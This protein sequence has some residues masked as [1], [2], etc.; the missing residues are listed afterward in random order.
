MSVWKKNNK[1]HEHPY[2]AP[3][4]VSHLCLQ[5]YRNSSCLCCRGSWDRAQQTIMHHSVFQAIHIDG[6]WSEEII[7]VETFAQSYKS[8]CRVAGM[9]LSLE[10]RTKSI[11]VSHTEENTE[12]AEITG[13][14]ITVRYPSPL[15][16]WR[17]T[18]L[19]FNSSSGFLKHSGSRSGLSKQ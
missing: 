19:L 14:L 7:F 3:A 6:L 13:V 18:C 17:S 12:A 11:L 4:C 2:T 9:S 1:F 10:Q 5:S 16:S 8:V 15:S